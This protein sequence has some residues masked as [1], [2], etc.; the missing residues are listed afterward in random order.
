MPGSRSLAESRSGRPYP[1]TTG[2][3]SKRPSLSDAT[4][5]SGTSSLALSLGL[6]ESTICQSSRMGDGSVVM[7]AWTRYAASR[8]IWPTR[9]ASRQEACRR[10]PRVVSLTSRGIVSVRWKFGDEP[11]R[12][13]GV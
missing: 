4:S 5:L 1:P 10:A 3:V 7:A 8:A 12:T 11:S 9:L 6:S 2:S 13:P